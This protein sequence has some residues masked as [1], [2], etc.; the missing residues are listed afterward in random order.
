MIRFIITCEH[1]G[2]R[3]PPPYRSIFYGQEALLKS[4]RGYDPG[5]LTMAKDLAAKL[6]ALL[7]VSVTSRLLIDLNRSMGHPH[8]FSEVT[9][10][11][12]SAIK[13]AII[14]K[15][16]E[17]YR[18]R[19]ESAIAEAVACGNSIIHISSHSFTAIL[20]GKERFTD[21]GLLYDPS[22]SRER[23]LCCF[24]QSKLKENGSELTIRRNYPYLGKAD[25]LTSY[26]RRQFPADRYLGI[27]LEINQKHVAMGGTHWQKLRQRLIGVMSRLP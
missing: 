12:P 22:R 24:W 20:N 15:Y 18:N 19:V 26:L 8:L 10:P 13:Q 25:G 21:I 17:P 3:I 16:Y 7:I 5:A 1:G 14:A 6:N 11:L 27:E 9:Q 4:H 23:E 2:N